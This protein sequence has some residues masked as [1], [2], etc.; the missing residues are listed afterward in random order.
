MG[1]AQRAGLSS[2]DGRRNA[3]PTLIN[4]VDLAA[5][6]AVGR[7]LTLTLTSFLHRFFTAFLQAARALGLEVPPRLFARV[8]EAHFVQQ[9]GIGLTMRALIYDAMRLV[10]ERSPSG[11]S[12]A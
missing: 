10:A 11:A 8:D 4:P 9:L 5:G 7:R 3:R 2:T 6:D 1:E 12:H